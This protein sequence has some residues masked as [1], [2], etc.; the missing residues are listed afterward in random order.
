MYAASLVGGLQFYNN[1]KGVG[2]F[3]TVG[4]L[5]DTIVHALKHTRIVRTGISTYN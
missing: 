1:N 2:L 3:G 4:T 5:W